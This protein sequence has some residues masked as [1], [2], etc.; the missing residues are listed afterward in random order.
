V[1]VCAS[2]GWE[3]E[4][5]RPG[6]TSCRE[7]ELA[8]QRERSRAYY[9]ANKERIKAQQRQSYADDPEA[10][11]ARNRRSYERRAH[12]RVLEVGAWVE[13]NPVA[14]RDIARRYSNTRRAKQA[15][16]FVEHVHPLVV[17]E[18]DDGMCG[19]CGEDVDPTEFHV[20][21]IWPLSRGGEHS[22]ANVQA[23]H[24][25]CNIRKNGRVPGTGDAA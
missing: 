3:T 11:R 9:E 8:A 25:L 5:H 7:C 16:A 15:E 2:C 23:A 13:A 10:G 21:H 19:I 22:Y 17:L 1:I 20:D 12:L 4:S 18:R 14:R 24:P 6:R